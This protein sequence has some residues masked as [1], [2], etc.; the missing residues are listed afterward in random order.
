MGLFRITPPS[1]DDENSEDDDDPEFSTISD[2]RVFLDERA[3]FSGDLHILHGVTSLSR[4]SLI[5]ELGPGP[6][7]ETSDFGDAVT[8]LVSRVSI[9][10]HEE[11]G[12]YLAMNPPDE[13]DTE[14]NKVERGGHFVLYSDLPKSSFIDKHLIEWVGKTPQT[15]KIKINHHRIMQ[16]ISN[17]PNPDDSPEQ[18]VFSDEIVFRQK[19][20]SQIKNNTRTVDRTICYYGNDAR[21]RV[22]EFYE[23]YD[24]EIDKIKIRVPGK[25]KFKIDRSGVFKLKSG[26]ITTFYQYIDSVIKALLEVKSEYDNTDPEEVEFGQTDQLISQ[27]RPARLRIEEGDSEWDRDLIDSLFETLR[28]HGYVPLNPYIEQ[29]PLYFASEIYFTKKQLYFDMRGDRDEMR[30]FPRHDDEEISTIY[31]VVDIVE[32]ILGEPVEAVTA[33]EL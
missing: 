9:S 30:F 20:S 13:D 24:L 21:D 31:A 26:S 19:D 11:T 2:F 3:G 27:S 18:R 28:S 7:L 17:A 6:W 32:S 14:N 22:G 33:R 5:E 1:K 8:K 10:N 29:D 12:F 4:E 16:I 15:T 23:Q 25:V